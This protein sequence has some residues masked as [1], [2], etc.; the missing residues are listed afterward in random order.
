MNDCKLW[1]SGFNN[2][3][4]FCKWCHPWASFTNIVYYGAGIGWVI[5]D[6]LFCW[7]QSFIHITLMITMIICIRNIISRNGF[8]LNLNSVCVTNL[9]WRC[10]KPSSLKSSGLCVYLFPGFTGLS[11]YIKITMLHYTA[12]QNPSIVIVGLQTALFIDLQLLTLQDYN[13][14]VYMY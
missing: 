13:L 6:I 11:S 5:A 2:I 3:Y 10:W 7:M 12:R 1:Y 4:L 8:P 14:T 9:V